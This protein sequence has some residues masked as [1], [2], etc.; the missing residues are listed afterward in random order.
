[1]HTKI[2]LFLFL[3]GCA[4]LIFAQNK[5]SLTN[6]D[7]KTDTSSFFIDFTNSVIESTLRKK[8]WEVLDVN[9]EKQGIIIHYMQKSSHGMLA[10]YQRKIMFK[11]GDSQTDTIEMIYNY[12]GRTLINIYLLSNKNDEK[13]ILMLKDWFGYYY[14]YLDN[15]SFYQYYYE[16]KN[17]SDSFPYIKYLGRIEKTR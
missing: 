8:S 1:M 17:I 4:N 11:I 16:A 13:K 15:L 6:N 12:G 3:M 5:D 9:L 10:E 2:L 14:F 7:N